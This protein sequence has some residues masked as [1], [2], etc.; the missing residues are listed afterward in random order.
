MDGCGAQDL[1]AGAISPVYEHRGHSTGWTD[2]ILVD[3]P[4]IGPELPI[5]NLSARAVG[6]NNGEVVPGCINRPRRLLTG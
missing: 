4:C 6:S 3:L 2:T 1:F 5:K